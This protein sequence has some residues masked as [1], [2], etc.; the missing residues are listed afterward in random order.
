MKRQQHVPTRAGLLVLLSVVLA[1]CG[2]GAAAGDPTRATAGA[3]IT[4]MP[5]APITTP[6]LIA[7]AIPPGASPTIAWTDGRRAPRGTTQPHL[8]GTPRPDRAPSRPSA[9]PSRLPALK[10]DLSWS[11]AGWPDRLRLPVALALGGRDHLYVVDAGAHQILK[12]DRDGQF[13]VMWGSEGSDV[14]QFRFQLADRCQAREAG[15]CRP[16]IGGGVAVDRQEHVY[17]ADYGNHRILKFDHG[18]TFLARWGRQGSGPGEFWRPSGIAVDGHD[19]IYVTDSDN[20][21]IQ[22]FDS[23]GR[24]LTEWETLSWS[25]RV[26]GLVVDHQGQVHVAVADIGHGRI[27]TLD[28]AGQFLARWTTD[29]E[30]AGLGQE[31]TSL[32]VDRQGQV[33]VTSAT[34][35][36]KF[37]Q[38]RHVLANWDRDWRG[39]GHLLHP[40]GIVV[41]EEGNVYVVEQGSHRLLKFRPLLPVTQ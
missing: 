40:R 1:A 33:Y 9:R 16:D 22:V 8:V 2:L 5:A 7:T 12:F 6:P 32:A 3:V 15:D 36:W 31:V 10:V 11:A 35:V 37:D 20:H 13:L 25:D 30:T 23:T 34:G 26:R 14:D 18:G 41:D 19:Q 17:V 24:F 4:P 39:Q 27:L 38:S 21:R 29:S 28:R